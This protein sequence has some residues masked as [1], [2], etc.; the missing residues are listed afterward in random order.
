[1]GDLWPGS[2]FEDESMG[3]SAPSVGVVTETL[4]LGSAGDLREVVAD[5]LGKIFA[6]L[7][8]RLE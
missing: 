8:R 1:M 3:E 4:A 6:K 7:T 5:L 2:D